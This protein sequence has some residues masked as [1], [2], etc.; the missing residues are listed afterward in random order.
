M[1]AFLDATT[2]MQRAKVRDHW[3]EQVASVRA[4]HTEAVATLQASHIE[5]VARLRDEHLAT[6][7]STR[8]AG[9]AALEQAHLR[10]KQEVAKLKADAAAAAAKSAERCDCLEQQHVADMAVARRRAT[11]AVRDGCAAAAAEARSAMQQRTVAAEQAGAAAAAEAQQAQQSLERERKDNREHQGLLWERLEAAQGKLEVE[12]RLHEQ[13]M[14]ELSE[15]AGQLRAGA[16]VVAGDCRTVHTALAR[17]LREN[18]E[19]RS[20]LDAERLISSSLSRAGQRGVGVQAFRPVSAAK[21]G[22]ATQHKRSH[23]T[24]W[25]RDANERGGGQGH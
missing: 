12:R 22:N 20:Q 18:S 19:L 13:R 21:H 3:Q 25:Q 11:A 1:L 14:R 15:E 9:E 8:A 10:H 7:H 23:H 5:E 17:V 4:W 16:A 2:C 24:R 6:L